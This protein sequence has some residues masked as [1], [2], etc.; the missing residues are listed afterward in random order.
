M[1][2]EASRPEPIFMLDMTDPTVKAFW[3]DE[4]E[5][6]EV[7]IETRPGKF[8]MGFKAPDI[9]RFVHWLQRRGILD[10]EV[11]AQMLATIERVLHEPNP[12]EWPVGVV[13]SY[14][15]GNQ[16]EA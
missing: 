1:N 14:T 11:C 13:P 6:N 8:S 2:H 3:E 15:S 12:F 16:A 5:T 10:P 9:R 4:P 7:Y